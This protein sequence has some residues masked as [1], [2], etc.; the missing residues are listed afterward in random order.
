MVTMAGQR[1]LAICLWI[2]G[3]LLHWQSGHHF[4]ADGGFLFD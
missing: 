4:V 3:L 1:T 2:V